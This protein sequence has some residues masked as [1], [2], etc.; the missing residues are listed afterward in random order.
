MGSLHNCAR[1][2]FFQ[3]PDSFQSSSMIK[4]TLF[5]IVNCHKDD[6]LKMGN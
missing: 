6:G 4:K 2:F 1:S 3:I 5:Y